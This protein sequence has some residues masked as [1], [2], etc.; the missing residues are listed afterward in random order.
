MLSD[1]LL[2]V[3]NSNFALNLY[4][5]N[6]AQYNR[7]KKKPSEKEIFKIINNEKENNSDKDDDDD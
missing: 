5:L 6:E 2:N 1:V 4:V 7:L 3:I